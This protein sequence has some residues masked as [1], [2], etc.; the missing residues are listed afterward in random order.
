[1]LRQLWDLQAT[2]N[3]QRGDAC[4]FQLQI[5]AGPMEYLV[6]S[7]AVMLDYSPAKT[8]EPGKLFTVDKLPLKKLEDAS[9]VNPEVMLCEEALVINNDAYLTDYYLPLRSTKETGMGVFQADNEKAVLKTILPFMKDGNFQFAGLAFHHMPDI[10][11]AEINKH[12]SMTAMNARLCKL[13]SSPTMVMLLSCDTA[14]LVVTLAKVKNNIPVNENIY[15]DPSCTEQY[16]LDGYRDDLGVF[17]RLVKGTT[18]SMK[19]LANPTARNKAAQTANVTAAV[20]PPAEP[21]VQESVAVQ[22][23]QVEEVQPEQAKEIAQ[24]APE[25]QPAPAHEAIMKGEIQDPSIPTEAPK[26]RTRTPK[27]ASAQNIN[28]C[29]N[30]DE[31]IAYLSSPVPD[32][33]PVEAMQDEVRKL[34]DLGVVLA[35]RQSNLFTAATASEKKLRDVLRGVLG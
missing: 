4:R 11:Q 16:K 9:R 25:I 20:T 13:R 10:L 26:K 34:R 2:Q 15:L 14:M 7:T 22:E 29:K 21:A 1:M 31:L 33:M 17:S 12:S 18:K 6:C 3:N 28:A 5:E 24:A 19:G 27:T 32:A 8:L 23:Q 30:I 35:R